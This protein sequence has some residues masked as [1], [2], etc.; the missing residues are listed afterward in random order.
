MTN[1][2]T[3][4]R[5]RKVIPPPWYKGVVD[6]GLPPLPPWIFDMLQYLETIFPSVESLWTSLQDKVYFI[7]GDAAEG[8]W[9]HQTWSPSWILSRIR[10]TE[11]EE[12]IVA[13]NAIY[14]IA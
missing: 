14:A 7:G 4:G 6:E 3:L 8:L 10:N 2:L 9:R 11:N 1:Y 13:V 5:K 12:M